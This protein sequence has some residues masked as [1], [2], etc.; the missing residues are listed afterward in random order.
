MN[1]QAVQELLIKAGFPCRIT[2]T[3]DDQQDGTVQITGT[4]L[5][6][7]VG[8]R[9][10]MLVRAAGGGA[11]QSK[12]VKLSELVDTVKLVLWAEKEI[13]APVVNTRSI[14]GIN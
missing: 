2:N 5:H 11:F 8:Q 6:V 14:P 7:Q 10:L 3:W 1:E 13:Q 12:A 9:Y 4:S